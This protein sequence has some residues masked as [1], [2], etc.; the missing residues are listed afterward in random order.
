MVAGPG[1]ERN[2]LQAVRK[3]PCLMTILLDFKEVPWTVVQTKAVDFGLRLEA[4]RGVKL[5]QAK[6]YAER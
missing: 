2:H 6:L 4:V 5:N 3:K 1:E